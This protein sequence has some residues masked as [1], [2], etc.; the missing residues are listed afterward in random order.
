MFS[1][2]TGFSVLPC[3]E[4]A[5]SAERWVLGK[6]EVAGI[7]M[8]NKAGKQENNTTCLVLKLEQQ[9]VNAGIQETERRLCLCGGLAVGYVHC[10]N[11]CVLKSLI[12]LQ[13]AHTFLSGHF[14]VLSRLPVTHCMYNVNTT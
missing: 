12:Y 14:Q 8:T 6:S 10:K 9:S 11:L 7:L 5:A 3:R 4:R 1:E 13:I 2:R